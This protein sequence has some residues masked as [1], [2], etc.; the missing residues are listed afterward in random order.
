MPPE[1]LYLHS[2][3]CTSDPSVCFD[4]ITVLNSSVWEHVVGNWQAGACPDDN[5]GLMQ[6]QGNG[7]WKIELILEN[8]FTALSGQ[9]YLGSTSSG[10]SDLWDTIAEPNPYTLGYVFRTGSNCTKGSDLGPNNACMDYFIG[11]LN[12]TP[13]Y[14]NPGTDPIT[15]NYNPPGASFSVGLKDEPNIVYNHVVYPNPSN[16][17]TNI[18]F[19]LTES[20]KSF[21]MK[22]FDATGTLVKTFNEGSMAAGDKKMIWDRTNNTGEKVAAGVY[23]FTMQSKNSIV[24][25]KI[26]VI[27]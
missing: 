24:S 26:V 22:I 8:Y 7:I 2:G 6:H 3:L 4:N 17:I 19:F 5:V 9:V 15:V 27:D 18:K 20:Q 16:E 10:E 23:Y 13:G 21:S 11:F 14:I 1:K 25:D 12:A